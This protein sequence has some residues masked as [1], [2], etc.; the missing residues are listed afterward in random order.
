M[1][2]Q[3]KI[4]SKHYE[5]PLHGGEGKDALHVHSEYE[6][7]G[8]HKSG[9]N[10]KLSVEGGPDA[11]RDGSEEKGA[12]NAALGTEGYGG[13]QRTALNYENKGDVTPGK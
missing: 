7:M 10:P 2:A 3:D 12:I 9:P 13:P 5:G 1:A 4:K 6:T 11:G 8:I